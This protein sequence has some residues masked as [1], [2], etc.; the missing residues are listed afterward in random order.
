MSD[1]GKTRYTTEQ[2]KVIESRG[3]NLLV[4]AAAGSGKTAVLVERIIQKILDNNHPMDIDRLLVVTFTEAAASEMRERIGKAIEEAL[5]KNPS[6]AHLQKQ[7]ALLYKAQ[8]STIHSFCMNIIRNNFNVIGLDPNFRVADENELTL[9][10]EDILDALFEEKYKNKDEQF[11]TLVDYFLKNCTDSVL[12]D[13]VLSLYKFSEG[14]PYPEEWLDECRNQYRINGVKEFEESVHVQFI[15]KYMREKLKDVLE[16]IEGAREIAAMPG[17]PAKYEDTIENDIDAVNSLLSASTY[18]EV[19]DMLNSFKWSTLPRKGSNDDPDVVEQFQKYRDGYKKAVTGD[20]QGALKNLFS[21]TAECEVKRLNKISPVIEGLVDLTKEFA[22]IFQTGKQEKGIISFSDMERYAL[23]ILWSVDENGEHIPSKTAL[24]YRDMFDELMMDEYQDCNRIQELLISSISN[25]S[26][27]SGNRFM[28]GDVKQS[29]YKFRLANPEI[30]IEKYKCY[31]TDDSNSQSDRIDTVNERIDLHKNFRSRRNVVNSVNDLFGQIMNESVGGVKY[32]NDARLVYGASFPNDLPNDNDRYDDD[33]DPEYDTELL[34]TVNDSDS[35]LSKG[36]SEA[37]LIAH[38]IKSLK[39]TLKVVDKDTKKL[40]PLRYSDIVILVRSMSDTA[41]GIKKIFAGEGIPVHMSMNSGFYDTRE[42]QTVI[43]LLKTIDNPRQDIALYGTMTSYFGNFTENDVA[44]IKVEAKRL[45]NE[46]KE[47]AAA[48]MPARS[49]R[50]L[51]D[52]LLL[53]KNYNDKV[54]GFISFLELWRERAVFRSIHQLILDLILESGFVDYIGA[55]P[56][57]DVR[58]SNVLLLVEQAK[59]FEGTNYR[60]LFNFVRYLEKIKKIN[61]DIGE[62][63]VLDENANVVRVMTIHKSKGLE[64]PV[65]FLAGVHK[66]FNMRDTTGTIVSDMDFGVGISYLDVSR[67]IKSTLLFRKAVNLKIRQ[68]TLGEEIRILY[69]ALTRAKEKMIITGVLK[70]EDEFD[71]LTDRALCCK[72]N[73]DYAQIMESK[74]YLDLLVP[75]Y[76]TAKLVGELDDEPD[77]EDT[78]DKIAARG[79]LR[80]HIENDLSAN[81]E[82]DELVKRIELEYPYKQLAGMVLKTSVS[83]IKKAY[84]DTSDAKELFKSDESDEKYIPKFVSDV[85]NTLSGTDRGS[86]YHKVMELLDF[87]NEDIKSQ[88]NS[89][90]DKKLISEAWAKAISATKIKNMMNS[91]LGQ[92]MKKA[93]Q[94]GLLRREQPFV[95]SIDANKANSEYPEGE[96]VLLQGIIDA[97]FIEDGEIVLMDYKTDVIKK[98]DNLIDRYAIQLDYYIEAL[99][100]ITGMHVKESLLYSFALEKEIAYTS[101]ER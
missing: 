78:F 22:D 14:Y 25:S 18:D 74:S 65:C 30:F 99:E 51:Y 91:N 59:K 33:P 9:L 87:D 94:I 3:K 52:S 89:W 80:K 79:E 21:E 82:V 41:E 48:N 5:D 101:C 56:G 10:M 7:A 29:I 53:V 20:N 26:E 27:Q 11:L 16:E 72:K 85:E 2:L 1:S 15:L 28:V 96:R 38:R 34:L 43:Q 77:I 19:N 67:R 71:S 86:A 57:G 40:R 73:M 88:I 90:I 83:D 8:I 61:N 68:D 31:K 45:L 36:E 42:I 95:L 92:R 58:S 54:A 84:L 64:F 93:Q 47:T 6:D 66:Q 100:R 24:E 63:D 50:C 49:I 23:N 97:F 60:G 76:N 13:A 46:Q 55:M 98:E 75:L 4:S 37:V 44:N 70:S 32:D 35:D 69:V 12:R 81:K 62:A 39:K 17:A